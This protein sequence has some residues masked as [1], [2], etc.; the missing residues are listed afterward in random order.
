MA[1]SLSELTESIRKLASMSTD[2]VLAKLTKLN[3]MSMDDVLAK[4]KYDDIPDLDTFLELT[5]PTGNMKRAGTNNLYGFNHRN[6]KTPVPENREIY[7]LTFFTRPQLN[8]SD[9]NLTRNR[10]FYPLLSKDNMSIQKYVRC[11]LDPRLNRP[12]MNFNYWFT[13][14]NIKHIMD[15]AKSAGGNELDDIEKVISFLRKQSQKADIDV[16]PLV[17]PYLGFIPVLS[18]NLISLS[19]WPDIAMSSYTSDQGH[20]RE[21]WI[22]MDSAYE[23]LEAFTL[24]ATFRNTRDE[25]ILLMF[26]MWELYMAQVFEGMM[27]PYM[28]MIVNNEMDYNTR[29]YRLV[30][31]ETKRF[32]KKTAACGA[33]FPIS[34]PTGKFFDYSSDEPYNESTKE[35]DISFQCVGADYNDYIT[36]NEFNWVSGMFNN[37]VRSLLKNGDSAHMV[38]IPRSIANLLNHRGYPIINPATLELQWWINISSLDLQRILYYIDLDGMSTPTINKNISRINDNGGTRTY[39]YSN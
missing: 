36:I 34:V 12:G 6:V 14:D 22:M 7:G 39:H 29:I 13:E 19:G 5:Q 23:Y 4:L 24:S 10:K 26:Q 32:V 27:M 3:E 16:C 20:K 8:F 25:P 35:I 33:A 38:K 18:N 30:L 1:T 31:D 15:G 2:D 28:D 37:N 17:D 9:Q 21:Q 11:M